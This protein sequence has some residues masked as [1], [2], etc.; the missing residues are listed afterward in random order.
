MAHGFDWFKL[1]ATVRTVMVRKLRNRG[2]PSS[3]AGMSLLE[4]MIALGIL[5]IASVGIMTMG[6]VAVS[7]TENQGHLAARTAEYAQDKIEQLNS[8]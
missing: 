4:V 5:L 8:L 2:F 3:Q 1:E 7:T 6:T